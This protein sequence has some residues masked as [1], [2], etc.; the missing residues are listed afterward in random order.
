MRPIEFRAIIKSNITNDTIVII[1]RYISGFSNIDGSIDKVYADDGSKYTSDVYNISLS[2]FT[3]LLDKKGI[4]IFEGDILS[5][6]TLQDSN[7]DYWDNESQKGIPTL[8]E[9][10]KRYVQFNMPFDSY[11]FEV[12]GNIYQSPELIK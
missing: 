3:G 12:I 4:K 2:Q 10:D 9:W 1:P 5:V 11:N 6:V 8:V 7:T